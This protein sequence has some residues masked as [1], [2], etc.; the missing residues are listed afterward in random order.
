MVSRALAV[1]TEFAPIRITH[2]AR[3][4]H[5]FHFRVHDRQLIGPDIESD[6]RRFACFEV[7]IAEA[8]RR[9]HRL[10][11][12]AQRVMGIRPTPSQCSASASIVT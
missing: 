4:N 10:H 8:A 5:S 6:S 2:G 12:A 7:Y 11:N 1:S 3:L 9:Y